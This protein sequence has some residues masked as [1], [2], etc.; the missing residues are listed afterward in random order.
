M[1]NLKMR[2]IENLY[3]NPF[4]NHS[5]HAD[6]R[7]NLADRFTDVHISVYAMSLLT[8]ISHSLCDAQPKNEVDREFVPKSFLK[9]TQ[10]TQILV[11]I[12]S[13]VSLMST[14]LC[15]PCHDWHIFDIHFLCL[16]M[17]YHI[18]RCIKKCLYCLHDNPFQGF[19]EVWN[20]RNHVFSDDNKW[21]FQYLAS[22]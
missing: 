22:C 14:L 2:S 11:Q 20:R 10:F 16:Y 9:I 21:E 1:H 7:P 18:P 12:S 19:G 15:T 5:I 6:S 13:T 17:S 3:R 8:Y 4:L